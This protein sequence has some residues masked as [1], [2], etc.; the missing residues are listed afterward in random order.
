MAYDNNNLSLQEMLLSFMSEQ[1]PMQ[2]MLQW[3]CEQLMDAEVSAKINAHKSERTDHR[4][5]YRSGFRVRRF[6]T[7]MG[8]MYLFVPK[9][10]KG[11]YIP[12]FVTE[13]S[14]SETAL[15][16]VIQEAYIN[17]LQSNSSLFQ[18]VPSMC[19]LL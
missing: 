19:F 12:F 14:R 10:R 3:L 2:A 13:K 15:M 9:I 1:D 18:R 5:G 17:S 16:N 4:Q 11:G 6:D 8:T 7:R